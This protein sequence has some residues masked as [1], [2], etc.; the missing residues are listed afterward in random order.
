MV[1]AEI[2]LKRKVD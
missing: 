2:E 1:Y